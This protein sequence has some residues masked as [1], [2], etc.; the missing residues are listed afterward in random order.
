M[1]LKRSD[2]LPLYDERFTGYGKNKIQF[3]VHLR[4]AG[5]S[6]SVLGGAFITHFPHAKSSS[7]MDWEYGSH[8][9][10]MNVLF[11]K[12]MQELQDRYPDEQ[13]AVHLC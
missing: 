4:Y 6:F 13:K 8:R 5:W 12:F 10:E 3:I 1:V 7:R 9:D 11:K 2:S